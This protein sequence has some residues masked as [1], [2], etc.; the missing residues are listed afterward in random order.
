M[1]FK[2]EL[3]QTL[4]DPESKIEKPKFELE[5]IPKGK[6]GGFVISRT[7]FGMSQLDR[8]NLVWDYLDAKLPKEKRMRIVT[9]VTLTP[10]EARNA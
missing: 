9:L 2:E 6:V 8:Q 3:E 4:S 5:S 1:E 10:G 7:F